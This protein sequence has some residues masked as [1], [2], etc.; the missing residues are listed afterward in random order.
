MV[1]D[2]EPGIWIHVLEHTSEY[3][4]M[5]SKPAKYFYSECFVWESV[6]AHK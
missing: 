6:F 2:Q 5:I 1:S 3:I 4:F